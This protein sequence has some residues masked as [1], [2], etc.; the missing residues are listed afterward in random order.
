MAAWLQAVLVLVLGQ[1]AGCAA[2]PAR[3]AGSP[4][5]REQDYTD[6]LELTPGLV[7]RFPITNGIDTH[8]QPIGN[9]VFTASVDQADEN[10]FSYI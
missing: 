8:W 4:A 6:K 2:A 7:V 3:A 1:L 10:G 5:A 9:Y